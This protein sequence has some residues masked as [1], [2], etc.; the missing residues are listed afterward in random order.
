MSKVGLSLVFVVLAALIC[1]AAYVR[2]APSDPAVWQ[3]DPLTVQP[4]TT[5]NFDLVRPED[6]SRSDEVF[7]MTPQELL[8]RF[9]EIVLATPRVRVLAGS[10]SDGFTTYIARSAF[11]GFPDYISVK[12]VPAE[13]GARLA[14]FSRARFG[15]SD[16]GVNAARM[17]G[18]M[19]QLRQQGG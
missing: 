6:G 3:V 5:P 9:N 13:G 12:A 18:W 8:E 1:F 11:W 7:A 10:V 19:Q 16:L 15:Q 14:A 2:L 17:E 4:P